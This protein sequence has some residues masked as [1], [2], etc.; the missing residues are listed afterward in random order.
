MSTIEL[1]ILRDD[2]DIKTVQLTR[3]AGFTLP[4]TAVEGL[5]RAK[6][7]ESLGTTPK[8]LQWVAQPGTK[9]V[10]P[11]DIKMSFAPSPFQTRADGSMLYALPSHPGNTPRR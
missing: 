7:A 6:I 4:R 1:F 3:P 2:T 11:E 9:S 8:D 5:M 10:T